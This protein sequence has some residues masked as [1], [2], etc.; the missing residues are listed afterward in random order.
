MSNSMYYCGVA[1]F[2]SH[3]TWILSNAFALWQIGKE[4]NKGVSMEG[5]IAVIWYGLWATAGN[6]VGQRLAIWWESR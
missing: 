5:V 3:V 4:F 2:F 1:S 6:I